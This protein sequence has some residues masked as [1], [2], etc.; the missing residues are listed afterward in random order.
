MCFVS[1]SESRKASN[2]NDYPPSLVNS[3]MSLKYNKSSVGIQVSECVIS[4]YSST[5]MI[6]E[7]VGYR[8]ACIQDIWTNRDMWG[9][10]YVS[11][12]VNAGVVSGPL[13]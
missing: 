6:K 12:G 7:H 4:N 11:E 1:L 2:V 8:N 13:N 10:I 3:L 9:S 5:K